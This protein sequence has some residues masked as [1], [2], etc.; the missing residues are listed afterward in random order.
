GVDFEE[1]HQ[2]RSLTTEEAYELFIKLYP[3]RMDEI[4]ISILKEEILEKLLNN[5]PLAI[6]IIT[7]NIPKNMKMMSLKSE[8]MNAFFDTTNLGY[9]DVYTENADKNI[10]RTES[11]FQ[12]INYSYV[13]LTSKEQRAL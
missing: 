2:L 5:N 9:K 10:E 6:K 7:K 12:S 3:V 8:L 13:R 11:L 4:D 1:K